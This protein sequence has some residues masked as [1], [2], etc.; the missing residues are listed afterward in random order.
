MRAVHTCVPR[1]FV[2][3]FSHGFIR[4]GLTQKLTNVLTMSL[5]LH[6]TYRLI[7]VGLKVLFAEAD[8][9]AH[10]VIIGSLAVPFTRQLEMP[11]AIHLLELSLLVVPIGFCQVDDKAQLYLRYTR[12][13]KGGGVRVRWG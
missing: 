6:H 12:R 13:G 4:A 8:E 11:T 10:N 5:L 7:R 2:I 1:L 3:K 9:C